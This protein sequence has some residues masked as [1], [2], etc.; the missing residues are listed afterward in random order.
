MPAIVS[1]R[2]S[3]PGAGAPMYVLELRPDARQVVVGPKV[4]LER[5]RLTASGVNW[6][7]TRPE[8][9]IRATVQ[10]RHRHPAAP[11]TVRAI[12]DARAEVVFDEPQ[13]A[14]TPG[15]AAVFYD[16]DI[17]VGGGWID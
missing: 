12:D 7:E 6:I 9:A 1:S 10:I 16:G 5:T 17:V 13:I 8:A 3:A 15:Q 14:V 2:L 11:A 4:S